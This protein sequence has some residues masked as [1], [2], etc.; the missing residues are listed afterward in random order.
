MGGR[1][2]SMLEALDRIREVVA[3]MTRSPGSSP[4]SGSGTS[5]NCS[6]R[7]VERAPGAA[8]DDPERDR[9]L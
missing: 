1:I 2:T 9:A 8:G 7:E 4:R 6:T 3:R 5:G